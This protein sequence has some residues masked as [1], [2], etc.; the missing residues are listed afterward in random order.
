M[1]DILQKGILIYLALINIWTFSVYGVDKFR[2][3]KGKWRVPELHL[4]LL[5]AAGGSFGA[6]IGMM[7]FHHKTRKWKFRLGVP[8]IL[9]AQVAIAW[10]VLN[11]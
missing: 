5:A 10:L 11:R 7:F 8:A 9:A 1:S 6:L 4:L 3:C 2:A